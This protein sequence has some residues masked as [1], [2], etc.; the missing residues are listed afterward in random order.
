LGS[1]K[2]WQKLTAEPLVLHMS[3]FCYKQV[4]CQKSPDTVATKK[5]AKQKMLSILPIAIKRVYHGISTKK[6]TVHTCMNLHVALS[7]PGTFLR[8]LIWPM[9][10]PQLRHSHR[11]PQQ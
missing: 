4:G 3:F 1:G 6:T 7:I 10:W 11:L 9:M 5:G 8:Y 2:K